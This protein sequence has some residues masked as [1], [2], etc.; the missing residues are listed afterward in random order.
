MSCKIRCLI[1]PLQF[2]FPIF[3]FLVASFLSIFLL[4][5]KY[6]FSSLIERERER[7]REL[8]GGAIVVIPEVFFPFLAIILSLLIVL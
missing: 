1:L 4:N 5:H 3:E 8:R 7:E 6:I 2:D